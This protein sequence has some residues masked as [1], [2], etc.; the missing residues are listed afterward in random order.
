MVVVPKRLWLIGALAGVVSGM[1]GVGGGLVIGQTLRY[2]LGL[3][4]VALQ[5]LE[6]R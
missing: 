6:S 4:L 5:V 3:P 2:G 1:L